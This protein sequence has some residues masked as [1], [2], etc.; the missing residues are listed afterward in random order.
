MDT[1]TFNHKGSDLL[2]IRVRLSDVQLLEVHHQDF[3]GFC[4]KFSRIPEHTRVL[5]PENSC[6][7]TWMDFE[8]RNIPDTYTTWKEICVHI[9]GIYRIFTRFQGNYDDFLGFS[10]NRL[11]Y[12]KL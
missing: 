6:N 3:R 7:Y 8:I 4:I 1:I 5:F 2:N 12:W 10:N 11:D 9:P